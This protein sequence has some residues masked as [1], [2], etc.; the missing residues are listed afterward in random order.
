MRIFIFMLLIFGASFSDIVNDS[1]TQLYFTAGIPGK[2]SSATS[3]QGTQFYYTAGVFGGDSISLVSGCDSLI[4]FIDTS[5][6][7][8]DA[9]A[10]QCSVVCDTNAVVFQYATDT[11]G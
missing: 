9:I 8:T 4:S 2:D 6:V 7:W 10:A 1:E 3:S 5:K 11:S